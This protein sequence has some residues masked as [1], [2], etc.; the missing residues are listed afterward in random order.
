MSWQPLFT[1]TDL[2]EFTKMDRVYAQYFPN[3]KPTRTTLAQVPPR[4]DHGPVRG[5]IYPTLEQI[6][7]IAVR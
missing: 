5:D 2:G 6:S 7:L 4:P 1:W 3:T